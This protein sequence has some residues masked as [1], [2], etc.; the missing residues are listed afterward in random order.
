MECLRAPIRTLQIILPIMPTA[1]AIHWNETALHYVVARHGH[2]EAS[3]TIPLKASINATELGNQLAVA[4][5]PYSPVHAKVIVALDRAEIGCQH[6]SLPPCPAEELPEVVR[7][8]ADRDVGPADDDLGFDFLPLLGDEQTPQQVLTFDMPAR[9][10]AKVRQVCKAANLTLERIVPLA[11]GWPALTGQTTAGITPGTHIFV[12]LRSNEATLWATRAGRMVLFRQFQLAASD[13]PAAFASQ[14]RGELRRTLL[15]LSQHT[16]NGTPSITLVGNQQAQLAALAQTLDEQLD[17][18][19]HSLDLTTQYPDL[20]APNAS[21]LSLV[22]LSVDESNGNRP[23]VDLLHPR[24]PP[25]KQINVRTYALAGVAGA[26]LLTLLGWSGYTKLRAPLDQA[27]ADQ[28]EL[29]LLEESLDTLKVH[30]QQASTIRDWNA[31][32]PNLLHHL[33]QVGIAIRPQ[34]LEDEG[35]QLDHD[36]VLDKLHLEKRQLTLEAMTRNSLAVQPLESRLRSSAYRSERIK[37]NASKTL[38]NY[39]WYLKSTVE[40]TT[41]SDNVDSATSGDSTDASSDVSS[42]EPQ[43]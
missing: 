37:S 35:F 38:D 36:V 33:Q 11:M 26:L 42:G 12:A 29:T 17:A 43:T 31:E 20:T 6:L 4:L 2:L 34:T 14:V 3:T 19:V 32:A 7:F 23:L 21:P 1:I 13:D 28:A 39:P 40:I 9:K 8:Q 10:L 16:G 30:E 22:G 18:S 27:A 25:K 15:A 24:Q 5:A 41:A